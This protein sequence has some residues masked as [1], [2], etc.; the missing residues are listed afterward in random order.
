MKID[1]LILQKLC[2]IKALAEASNVEQL[3]QELIDAVSTQPQIEGLHLN[4][5]CYDDG[6]TGYVSV[7]LDEETNTYT[8][9]FFDDQY[10]Q[11]IGKTTIECP[12]Q[13]VQLGPP[14]E[15]CI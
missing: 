2:D 13:I 11:V 9:I 5:V 8:S 6:S 10:Q 1:K 14:I 4:P 15:R 3:L 12:T 7:I